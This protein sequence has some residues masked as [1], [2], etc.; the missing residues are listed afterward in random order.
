MC[1]KTVSVAHLGLLTEGFDPKGNCEVTASCLHVARKIYHI[2]NPE[3]TMLV[4]GGI[5]LI[6]VSDIYTAA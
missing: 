4:D 2:L 3:I 5:K 6:T 1:K